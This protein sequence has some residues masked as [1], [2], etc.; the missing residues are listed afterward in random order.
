MH[1]SQENLIRDRNYFFQRYLIRPASLSAYLKAT[2]LIPGTNL[3][4]ADAMAQLA[5]TPPGAVLCKSIA[6]EITMHSP[7][8]TYEILQAASSA[9]GAVNFIGDE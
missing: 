1:E 3:R 5:A 8:A 4:T 7:H 9:A 2:L 6:Y